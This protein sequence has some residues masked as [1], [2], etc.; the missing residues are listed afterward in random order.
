MEWLAR[1]HALL[2]HLPVATGLLLPWALV[3]AQRRGRGI[4]SWWTV[5]RYL[6]WAGVL[7]GLGA[8]LSGAASGRLAT[9]VPRFRMLPGLLS[10]PG[11][12]GLLFRHALLAGA[13][14]LLGVAACWALNRHRK[15]HESLGLLA[16]ALGLAW[17]AALLA[18]GEGGY[19]LAHHR[20][21]APVIPAQPPPGAAVLV[22]PA[23]PSSRSLPDPDADLPVRALDYAALEALHPDPVKS[24]AHGGRWVRAWASP[25]AAAAYRAGRVL[26]LGAFVVLS[27]LE[28]RW[29]RPGPDP[30]PIYAME[31]KAA[32]PVFTFYWPRIPVEHRQ[33]F[34]GDARAYWRGGDAHLDACRTCHVAGL[35]EAS[36]RSRWRP[37]RTAPGE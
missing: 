32:G 14:L 2:S 19:R 9:L 34:A 13:A 11:V 28:D 26:P 36:K 10:S 20:T 35:A 24:L 37:R 8:F 29:G 4:R 31:M 18:T 17:C 33:E 21:G 7:G 5:A 30:G 12:E 23:P 6:G 25:E 1:Q 3:A 15:D 22:P 16:L 27:S